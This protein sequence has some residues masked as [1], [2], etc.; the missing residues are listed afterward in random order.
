MTWFY[1]ALASPF[2][3]SINNH[4]DKYLIDNYY[5]KVRAGTLMFLT[6][7]VSALFSLVIFLVKPEIINIPLQSIALVLSAGLLYF[8]AIFPY[9][10]ALLRDEAS[11][12][13]PLFQVQPIFSYL[14]AL[15]FLQE[16]LSLHQ[17][18]AG[19]VI[20]A[21]AVLISLDLDDRFRLKKTVF[22]LMMLSTLFFSVE[23]F[24]FKFV[25]VDV[26]FWS[27]A[28]YQ[29]LGTALAGLGLA[30]A[31]KPYREDFKTVMKSSGKAVVSLS[32]LNETINVLA[33][34]C[35]NYA[36]LLAP[37][38]LVAVVNGFQPFFVIVMGIVVTLFWP[39]AGKESLER[40][41]LVQKALSV[42][43]IFAGTYLLFR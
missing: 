2:L 23:G 6:A 9:I 4:I 33:R 27:T 3:W 36:S 13:V 42:V 28:F 26:G 1:I 18:A 32:V 34:V 35:F 8:L 7:G 10:F 24:L 22:G 14:L 17:L 20:I 5:R 31:S 41:H 40:R 12:V 21:G 11:R 25:A 39:A 15:V 29:Y 30:I 38:A 37:L 43:V 16:S 19:L